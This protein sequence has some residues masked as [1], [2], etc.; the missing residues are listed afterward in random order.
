M[1]TLLSFLKGLPLS[2][3]AILGLLAV[4]AFLEL[5]LTHAHKQVA[6]LSLK[7]LNAQAT[8]DSTHHAMVVNQQLAERAAVQAALEKDSL[9]N[10]LHLRPVVHDT[11]M[12]RIAPVQGQAE[13]T[14]DTARHAQFKVDNP[15]AH[16]QVDV[17]VQDTNV[18]MKYKLTFDP[19]PVGVRIGCGKPIAGGIS[20]ATVAVITPSWMTTELVQVHQEET[21]C[22]PQRYTPPLPHRVGGTLLTITKFVGI[23]VGAFLLG[24]HWH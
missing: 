5:S 17:I 4:I 21:V 18:G 24:R 12:E 22:N 2:V 9:A 14:L 3:W 16:L 13:A 8:A 20:P 11:I 15:P 19:I 10:A 23:G 6:D 7:E 1:T